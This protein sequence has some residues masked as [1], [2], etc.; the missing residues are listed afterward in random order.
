MKG[1]TALPDEVLYTILQRV[2]S[3][4]NNM[5]RTTLPLVCKKWREVLYLQGEQEARPSSRVVH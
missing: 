2:R 5:D 4:W 1:I 3:P